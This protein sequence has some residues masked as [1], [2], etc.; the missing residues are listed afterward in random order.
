VSPF[1]SVTISSFDLVVILVAATPFSI[2]KLYANTV[3]A[4]RPPSRTETIPTKTRSRSNTATSGKIRR[5]PQSRASTTSI[6]S[7]ATQPLDLTDPG[8]DYPKDWY[9]NGQPIQQQPSHRQYQQMSP[10]DMVFQS[11]LQNQREYGLDPA[12]RAAVNH[13]LAYAQEHQ[14]NGQ[15]SHPVMQKEPSYGEEDSQMIDN[16][17]EEQDEVDSQGPNGAPKKASKASAAN[18]M[19][20]RQLFHANKDR[21]LPDVASELH[22][23]ERGPQSERTR[24][25]FAMLW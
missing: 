16:R 13:S 20:M 2:S 14:Y 8:I 15:H 3:I 10:E 4:D 12:L 23:N 11:H 7:A 1:D 6:H 18:E 5:R 24:Q 9:E 22:G 19:E 25:V 17:S 21:T